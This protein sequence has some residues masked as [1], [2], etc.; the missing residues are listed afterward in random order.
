LVASEP[1]P[2]ASEDGSGPPENEVIGHGMASSG[3]LLLGRRTYEE[4]ERAFLRRRRD[5]A[6]PGLGRPTANPGKA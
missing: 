2:K 5:L 3:G 1:G 6:R 4:A